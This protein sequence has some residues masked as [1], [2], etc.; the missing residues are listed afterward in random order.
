MNKYA[1]LKRKKGIGFSVAFIIAITF[2]LFNSITSYAST[3]EVKKGDTLWRISKEYNLSV[4]ELKELNGLKSDL[5]KIGQILQVCKTPEAQLNE[6]QSSKTLSVKSS[7]TKTTSKL[8]PQSTEDE[9]QSTE[10]EFQYNPNIRLSYENQKYLYDLTQQRGLDYKETLA[11][12]MIESSFRS[13]AVSGNNYGY[14]QINK[15]NH[16][17]L[18]KTLKTK[19]TPLDPKTNLNWGTYMLSNIEMKYRNQGLTG[20][21]LRESVLSEYN[22]GANG[23][24]K[25]GKSTKYIQKYYKALEEIHQLYS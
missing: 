20:K 23:F 25:Y 22:R 15:V 10:D 13:N 7:N 1:L 19:N 24:K 16:A 12:I 21:E 2:F 8:S 18:A 11:V 5:I 6:A 17:S 14:F 9:F 4:Q 3:Y